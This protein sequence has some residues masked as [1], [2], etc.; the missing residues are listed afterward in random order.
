MLCPRCVLTIH[1]AATSCPHCGFSLT[2]ADLRFGFPPEITHCLQD[3]AGIIRNHEYARIHKAM[4]D[5][6]NRF[7]Q[8]FVAAYTTTLEDPSFLREFGFWLLNRVS[9][10]NS[11][12]TNEAAILI[13]IDPQ[14]KSASMV[15][16]YQVDPYL[17]EEDTFQCLSTGHSYWIEGQFAN[18]IVHCIKK[19]KSILTKRATSARRNPL[20][21][22]KKICPPSHIHTEL[23]KIR[24]SRNQPTY[25]LKPP[26]PYEEDPL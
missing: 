21:F 20:P 8:L 1:R 19:L 3:A 9:F 22:L 6:S 24:A 10:T 16:G 11:T 15:F 17:T 5:F 7:P 14:N 13:L 18:G 2:D 25:F 12:M 26:I 23:Q 4:Q